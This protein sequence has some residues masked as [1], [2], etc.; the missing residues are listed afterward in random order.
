MCILLPDNN[1][2]SIH[3]L[4]YI[5]S[6]KLPILPY[7]LVPFWSLVAPLSH[8]RARLFKE[9]NYVSYLRLRLGWGQLVIYSLVL[10]TPL[11][12]YASFSVSTI[13]SL[14]YEPPI[15]PKFDLFKLMKPFSYALFRNLPYMTTTFV[16]YLFSA[17]F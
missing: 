11:G 17:V 3:L 10:Y 4:S 15:L 16:K 6:F 13:F 5:Q 9:S 7:C 1:P 8:W 2:H 14:P 12:L